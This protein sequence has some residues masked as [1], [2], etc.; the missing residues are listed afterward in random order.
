MS[1]YDEFVS[2]LKKETSETE[3]V[4]LTKEIKMRS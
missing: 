4:D 1:K 2:K 3:I